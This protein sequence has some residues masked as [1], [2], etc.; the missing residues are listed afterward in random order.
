MRVGVHMCEDGWLTHVQ[1]QKGWIGRGGCVW[2]LEECVLGHEYHLTVS[3]AQKTWRV[4]RLKGWT[5][6]I[7]SLTS[8]H[9]RCSSESTSW[10][11]V[12]ATHTLHT[13][14]FTLPARHCEAM[15]WEGRVGGVRCVGGGR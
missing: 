12:Q 6:H 1:V 2:L 9:Q 3:N 13:S 4:Q 5:E 14:T 10:E 15:G 7:C 8:W 11:A